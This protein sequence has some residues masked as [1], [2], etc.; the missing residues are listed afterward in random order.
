MGQTFFGR[1]NTIC[2]KGPLPQSGGYKVTFFRGDRVAKD[3][4][5]STLAVEQAPHSLFGRG[6]K[7][8]NY[9]SFI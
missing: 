1:K 8:L 4:L 5:C 3:Y 6:N 2:A 9:I 7:A